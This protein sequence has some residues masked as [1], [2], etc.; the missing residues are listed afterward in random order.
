MTC[1]SQELTWFFLFPISM[2]VNQKNTVQDLKFH[3]F[4]LVG[5]HD[6]AF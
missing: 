4:I 6:V 5:N 2:S 1:L 3:F